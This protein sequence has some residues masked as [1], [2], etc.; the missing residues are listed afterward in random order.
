M[1]SG[2]EA[3][4]LSSSTPAR[5]VRLRL[6]EFN[7][8]FVPSIRNLSAAPNMTFDLDR[9]SIVCRQTK[10]CQIQRRKIVESDEP[11]AVSVQI[12][13]EDDRASQRS[14]LVDRLQPGLCTITSP[15]DAPPLDARRSSTGDRLNRPARRRRRNLLRLSLFLRMRKIRC[16]HGASPLS[17]PT[18]ATFRRTARLAHKQTTASESNT[19]ETCVRFA[20]AP[21]NP[22]RRC[23]WPKGPVILPPTPGSHGQS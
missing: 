18:S 15:V 21:Y 6:D 2:N 22:Y 13:A 1:Q 19:L 23:A 14:R 4:A 17:I 10:N 16:Q 20:V 8:P 5:Q 11:H 7:N 3:I 9:A 12:A